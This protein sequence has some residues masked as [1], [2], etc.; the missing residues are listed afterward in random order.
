M[1]AP[2][3]IKDLTRKRTSHFIVSMEESYEYRDDLKI[4]VKTHDTFSTYF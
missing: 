3:N 4:F 1:I 2:R